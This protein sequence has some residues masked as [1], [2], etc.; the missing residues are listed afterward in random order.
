MRR[1]VIL[2][3]L[4][5]WFEFYDLFFSGY[6]APALYQ[7]GIYTPT[8]K[9][10]LGATGFASFVAALFAGLFL[11]TLFMSQMSDRLGRRFIFSSS[12]L[13][14]SV[15]T[16]IMAFQATAG[17]INVWRFLA[18]V[19]LG[20]QQ[21]TID[22]YISELAPND[23]RGA[24]FAFS[25]FLTFLAV[26][27]AALASWALLPIKF[28]GLDG[29]R[30]VVLI[31]ASGGVII[32]FI[33][34]RIPESPRWL[35]QHGRLEEA[36]RLIAEIEARVRQ[37]TG[38][39]LPP[40]KLIEEEQNTEQ[41]RGSWREM[42]EKKYRGRTLM[43]VA[44]HLV[45]PQGYYGF[46]NWAPTFL[47]A[48]GID[49]TKTL[50]Y[51]AVIAI[52]NPLGP[53][54]GWSVADRFERKW[55]IAWSALAVGGFGLLFGAQKA[56]LGVILFGLLVTLSNNWMSFAFHAYEAELYPTR[57]R[58]QAV[59]FVYSWSRFGVI[60]SSFVI[61]YLLRRYGATGAF[62]YMAC[63]MGLVFLVIGGFGPQT[64]RRR[65]EQI[66]R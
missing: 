25:Q 35:E 51:I 27:F 5:A 52:A 60:L 36:E 50:A 39:E 61:A 15:C 55:Q 33:R 45:W 59:G 26:P 48:E 63:T 8:T 9:G 19:G 20:V 12:L 29:W 56:A 58:S 38:K 53:L 3:S 49:V 24:A 32:W 44:F 65:L 21:V 57:I 28:L 13:W 37:Q 31:G 64:N 41:R 10:F 23:T 6:I 42:W 47:L 14:Y 40:P 66:A 54:L 62:V 34:R 4:G 1:L 43:L 16:F 7:S 2:L 22:T 11:G 30:W 46:A 17:A 18:G